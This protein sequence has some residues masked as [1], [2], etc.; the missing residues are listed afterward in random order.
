MADA[1][2]FFDTFYA[3]NNVTAALVGN[4][5]IDGVRRLAE[6][7]FGRIP[8]GKREVPDV[9]TLEVPQ[10]AEKRMNAEC[11][12]QP[13]VSI[14]FHSVPFE[15]KDDYVF[16]V[17]SGLLNGQT[18]RLNKSLVLEK[19]IAA[20]A[21]ASES[22]WKYNGY[23]TLAA[24]TRGEATPAD[25][26]SALWAEVERL[27]SEPVPAEELQKVKNQ[28]VADAYRNLQNPFFLLIQL[29]F[30]EGW[31]DWN[32]LNTWADQT[33]AVTAEDVQRVATKYL[34]KENR[35][36]ATYL[37]KA[38]TAAEALPPELEGLPANVRQGIQAQIRQ[39]REI[40]DPAQLEA[41]LANMEQQRS[42]V[43]PELAGAFDLLVR[44]ARERLEELRAAADEAHEGGAQ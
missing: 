9:V 14:Q 6:K 30:Y 12:C 35:T 29:L 5:E 24:E 42:G 19:K 44:T 22:A 17:I 23:F 20:S 34:T 41:A 11:D 8:R 39:I 3:P 31:G 7:Y 27:K 2:E 32:Y 21:S 38:G 36:V 15:H 26:E 43:P 16:E 40:D 18:G 1:Q 33:V 25:L 13:Q 28:V 10:L 37:R 4:F